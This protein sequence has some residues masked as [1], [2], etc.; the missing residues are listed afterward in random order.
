MANAND[1]LLQWARDAH[2]MEAQAETMLGLT[3]SRLENFPE[4]KTR[5]EQHREETRR[6]AQML[7]DAIE[8]LGGDTS[9]VKDLAG[10][11]MATAQGLSGM[12]VGDEVAK[13]LLA[14]Y[15]F[16]H[17][18][19]ASYRQLISA[20]QFCGRPQFRQTCEAILREEEAMA[21]WLAEQMPLFVT[22]YLQ[23]EETPGATAKH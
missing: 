16:E 10:K 5:L 8:R 21:S 22:R 17:M 23:L 15:T 20:A 6:Q 18:E 19:I 12:L 7:Q 1:R 11:A 3:A 9:A 4:L 13:A 14:I 2:A